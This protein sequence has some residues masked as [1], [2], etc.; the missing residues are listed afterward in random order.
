M[1]Q[2]RQPD[3]SSQP[4]TSGQYPSLS[5]CRLLG[6]PSRTHTNEENKMSV[7]NRLLAALPRK[8]YQRLLPALERVTLTFG[9][10]LYEPGKPI[11]HVYFPD[12]A[13]ISLLT[14]ADGHLALEVGMVGREGMIGTPVALGINN[15]PVR[16]LVQGSGTA[17]RMTAAH[18]GKEFALA[19]P[20]QQLLYRYTH[21]LMA[22][23]TQTAACNRFHV[24][25]QR[26]A[27]WLLMT[28]DRVGHDQFRLTQEFLSHMLGVR[29]VGITRAASI[30]QKRELITYSRGSITI[31][32]RAGLEAYACGCYRTVKDYYERILG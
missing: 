2:A 24:V 1:M 16:A 7:D 18:F 4:S 15:S 23:V 21:V 3:F 5:S 10:I 22:Q 27:R 11:G 14:L 20:L 32:D 12:N 9:E 19:P 26:L 30:L 13:L 28:L 25:E 17:M 8:N 29:R 31:L 6:F